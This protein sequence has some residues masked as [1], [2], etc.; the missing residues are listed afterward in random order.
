VG[1]K[2][3][4]RPGACTVPINECCSLCSKNFQRLLQKQGLKFKLN[5]KVMRADKQADGRLKVHYR[6]GAPD[7]STA[8][9]LLCML[10]YPK[11]SPS[12]CRA[13]LC[14]AR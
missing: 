6:C 7:V 12:P 3:R 4:E 9:S 11:R 1:E 5:T 8:H 13:G 2:G 14:G 10:Y